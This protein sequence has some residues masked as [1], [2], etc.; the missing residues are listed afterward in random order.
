MSKTMTDTR[1]TLLSSGS[2]GFLL[3]MN[4]F[5]M[6]AWVLEESRTNELEY[7]AGK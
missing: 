2:V 5:W 1:Y 4:I 7:L 6:H 3:E